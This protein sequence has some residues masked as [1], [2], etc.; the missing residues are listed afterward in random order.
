MENSAL[1][2]Y[3]NRKQAWAALLKV[4]LL[5]ILCSTRHHFCCQTLIKPWNTQY[6]VCR[7]I[8][9]Q[10]LAGV[11]ATQWRSSTQHVWRDPAPVV[12]SAIRQYFHIHST[13]HRG[14]V[15]TVN[16]CH[17]P[18]AH[19]ADVLIKWRGVFIWQLNRLDI[20]IQQR[21]FTQLLD[22]PNL[23]HTAQSIVKREQES[24]EASQKM[25]DCPLSKKCQKQ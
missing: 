2:K 3:S 17:T 13:Q 6:T 19:Y 11:F 1:K 14:E 8:K 9:K 23:W 7:A 10:H 15:Q 25:W 18:A 16:L 4:G 5:M 12:I 24:T 21:W 22:K 20:G